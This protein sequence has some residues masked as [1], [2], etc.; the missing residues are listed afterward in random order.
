MKPTLII[1]RENMQFEVELFCDE[2]CKRSKLAMNRSNI[3]YK[4]WNSESDEIVRPPPT[5]LYNL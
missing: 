2:F 4:W 1:S 3:H 5:P